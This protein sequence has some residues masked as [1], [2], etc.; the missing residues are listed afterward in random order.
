MRSFQLWEVR[1]DD[2]VM[3]YHRSMVKVKVSYFSSNITVRFKPECE[4]SATE[5]LKRHPVSQTTGGSTN[6][7]VSRM[8]E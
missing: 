7:R 8:F 2:A 5:I 3:L 1:T 4:D 6:E